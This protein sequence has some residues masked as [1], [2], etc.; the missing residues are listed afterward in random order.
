MSSLIHRLLVLYPD[1][2]PAVDYE[3]LNDHSGERI[4]RWNRSDIAP[5][6][7]AQLEAA[8]P[9]ADILAE[10][11]AQEFERHHQDSLRIEADWERLEDFLDNPGSIPSTDVLKWIIEHLK[12]LRARAGLPVRPRPILREPTHEQS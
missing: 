3:I 11:M 8:R 4:T 12:F 5:P 7:A 6:T 9:Q 1:L 10:S 2:Q